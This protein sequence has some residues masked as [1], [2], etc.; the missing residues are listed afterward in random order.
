MGKES[1]AKYLSKNGLDIRALQGS[2]SHCLLWIV[3]STE[4]FYDVVALVSE[5]IMQKIHCTDR[6][7]YIWKWALKGRLTQMSNKHVFSQ[8]M[9]IVI[10]AT[11]YHSNHPLKTVGTLNGVP[12][13]ARI[14]YC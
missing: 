10:R 2:T 5:H 12:R 7:D 6:S 14:Y 8:A 3:N 4:A 13:V 9:Q 11:F 1:R